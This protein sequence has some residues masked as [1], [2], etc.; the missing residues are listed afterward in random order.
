[1]NSYELL[2]KHRSEKHSWDKSHSLQL[3]SSHVPSFV[4]VTIKQLNPF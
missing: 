4:S 2:E 1:M 3:K